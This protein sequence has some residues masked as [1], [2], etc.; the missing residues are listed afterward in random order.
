[1]ASTYHLLRVPTLYFRMI[2][3]DCTGFL[4]RA[5][6]RSWRRR[7]RP[8]CSFL[9]V[10][11]R[12]SGHP[13]SVGVRPVCL[14]PSLSSALQMWRPGRLAV[15]VVRRLHA[16]VLAPQVRLPGPRT[17]DHR[18]VGGCQAQSGL[19]RPGLLQARALRHHH[20]SHRTDQASVP[21]ALRVRDVH[22]RGEEEE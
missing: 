7:G 17:W 14:K 8:T 5:H 9:S 4:F 10:E 22:M 20:R 21:E 15:R 18:R 11:T 19:R 16:L 1:M 6:L 12:P 3:H 13:V 2:H